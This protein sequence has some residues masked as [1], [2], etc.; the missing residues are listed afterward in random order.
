M[1]VTVK[2]KIFQIVFPEEISVDK[3]VAQRSQ[4]T[5]HLVLKMPKA[6]YKIGQFSKAMKPNK[7]VQQNT[8]PLKRNEYLEI[9]EK[10]IWDISKI[11]EGNLSQKFVDNAEVP[12]LEYA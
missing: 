6:N 8:K 1:K 3:S 10:E 5:G 4:T 9:E 2:N 12:P 7:P 11:V